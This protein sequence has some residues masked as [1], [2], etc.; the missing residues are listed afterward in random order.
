VTLALIFGFGIRKALQARRAKPTTGQEGLLGAIG[1][2]K[3]ALEPEG[4]VFVWGERWRATSVDGQ[5]IPAGARVK[6]A[7][8]DGFQLKV[9]KVS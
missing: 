3:V 8:I 2:V 9:E 4:S 1:T 5:S 6:V 7:A